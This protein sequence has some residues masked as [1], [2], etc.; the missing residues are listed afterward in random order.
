MG[1]YI[2]DYRR[3]VI[4]HIKGDT[5]LD[6]T[7]IPRRS[8]NRAHIPKPLN[9]NPAKAL[10]PGLHLGGSGRLSEYTYNPNER[11][12]EPSYPHNSPTF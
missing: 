5:R 7:A 10:N 8:A 4:G 11:Y 6:Y 9:L 3:N 1:G 12:N 2:G